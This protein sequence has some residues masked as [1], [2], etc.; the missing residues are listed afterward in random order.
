MSTETG[1]KGFGSKEIAGG[2]VAGVAVATASIAAYGNGKFDDTAVAR[3]RQQLENTLKAEE[4]AAARRIHEIHDKHPLTEQALKEQLINEGENAK[5]AEIRAKGL[6][7]ERLAARE[8]QARKSIEDAR[9]YLAAELEPRL[10]RLEMDAA[11]WK[12]AARLG[13]PWVAFKA[14]P[15]SVK[16]GVIGSAAAVGL[17]IAWAVNKWRSSGLDE[18]YANR[19]EAERSPSDHPLSR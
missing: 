1:E 7:R 4:E 12:D 2:A 15:I 6:L 3:A 19:I 14:A 5:Y 13:K 10:N 11:R 8:Q 17:G 18:K 16:A 9:G